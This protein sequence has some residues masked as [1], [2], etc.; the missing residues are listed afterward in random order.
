[1]EVIKLSK[2]WM[3][4]VGLYSPLKEMVRAE[5]KDTGL[6]IA[7]VVRNRLLESYDRDEREWRNAENNKR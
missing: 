4:H 6:S 7:A 1:M 2:A 5:V 3:L